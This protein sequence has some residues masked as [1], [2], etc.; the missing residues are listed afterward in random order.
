MSKPGGSR[1]HAKACIK[2]VVKRIYGNKTSIKDASRVTRL[3]FYGLAPLVI[4]VLLRSIF[5]TFM[6]DKMDITGKA[7]V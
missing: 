7:V 4:V 3:F 6:C 5:K 1:K 2:F